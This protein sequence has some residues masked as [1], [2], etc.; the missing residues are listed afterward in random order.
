MAKGK[1]DATLG[2]LSKNL[3]SINSELQTIQRSIQLMREAGK[4]AKQIYEAYGKQLEKLIED[5]SKL[6]DEIED[7]KELVKNESATLEKY[8]ALQRKSTRERKAALAQLSDIEL[9]EYK[10]S[11][12][13]KNSG[14]KAD[15][16]KKKGCSKSKRQSRASKG[17][18]LKTKH[19]QAFR[20]RA[21][22][23][24]IRFK[25]ATRKALRNTRMLRLRK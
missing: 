6:N 1:G 18:F 9:K 19:Q 17:T 20:G 16:Q 10:K 15:K 3:V 14:L 7:R 21:R 8:N 5:E 22:R 11:E 12:N 2:K 4:S 13:V 23:F 24:L 25:D